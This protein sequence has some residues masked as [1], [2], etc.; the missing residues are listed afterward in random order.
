LLAVLLFGACRKNS[1]LS[2]SQ[3]ATTN[4]TANAP[5]A[6]PNAL[7]ANW[8]AKNPTAAYYNVD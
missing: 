4:L 8:F 1:Y 5:G 6:I 3:N 2:P 7:I